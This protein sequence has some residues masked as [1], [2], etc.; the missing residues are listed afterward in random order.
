M[1]VKTSTF[2]TNK[3]VNDINKAIK[4]KMHSNVCGHLNAFSLYK[5]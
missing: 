4:E 3:L 1:K 2:E 5:R